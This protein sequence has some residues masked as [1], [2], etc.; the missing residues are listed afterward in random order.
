VQ[1][2]PKT[3]EAS[4]A[5]IE[6][7]VARLKQST[8]YRGASTAI[9][10][11]GA[12]VAVSYLICQWMPRQAGLVWPIANALGLFATVLIGWRQQ[13]A[14][15]NFDWR[16]VIAVVLIFGF[17]FICSGL[18][19]FGPRELSVFWPILF[20]FGYAIAGL[21]LGRAFVLLGVSVA[22][23]AFAGYLLSRPGFRPISRS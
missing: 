11:W 5:D 15:A 8:Y 3:A 23:L 12:L 22:L 7:V 19:H 10:I 9:I 18:G 6:T 20:M 14:S 21:W 2:D 16:I 1:L 17:G 13:C 4:L